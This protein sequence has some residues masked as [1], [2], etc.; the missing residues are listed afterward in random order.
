M[1]AV[2]VDLGWPW[3]V[4]T[5]IAAGIALL[6]AWAFVRTRRTPIRA[7]AAV[8]FFEAIAAGA[9][10]PFVMDTKDSN[11][12]SAMSSGSLSATEYARQADANC[13]KFGEFAATLG[14]PTTPGGIERQM[15]RML[16]ALWRAYVSQQDLE[17]PAEKQETAKQWMHAMAA[18]AGDN[19]ALRAAAARA[20]KRTMARANASAGT[21]A[22]DASRLSKELGMRVCFQ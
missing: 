8:I 3:W 17:P 12:A 16:P 13:Q 14:S 7:V 1:L 6:A 21:H 4:T 2:M 5:L 10:A 18:F 15:D 9:V 19:E 20:D 22:T 11:K